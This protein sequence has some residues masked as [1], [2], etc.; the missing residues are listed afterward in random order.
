MRLA[1]CLLMAVAASLIAG[2]AKK[3]AGIPATSSSSATPAVPGEKRYP[4]T[5]EIVSVN[6]D[7]K[8]L[9]VTHDEIKGFMMGMTMEFKVAKGDFGKC[10]TGTADSR[11]TGGAGRRIIARKDLAR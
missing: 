6:P 1:A 2:C 10:E 9:L 3:D 5:G 11:R 8:T 7:R 4:L